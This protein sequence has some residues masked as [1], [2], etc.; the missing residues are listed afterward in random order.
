MKQTENKRH[1]NYIYNHF[2]RKLTR[3]IFPVA[4]TKN[5]SFLREFSLIKW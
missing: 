4:N 5:S 3:G 2:V 1:I